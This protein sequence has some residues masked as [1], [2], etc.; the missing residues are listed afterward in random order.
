MSE[1]SEQR[2]VA[3]EPAEAHRGP[4]RTRRIIAAVVTVVIVAGLATYASLALVAPAPGATVTATS[5]VVAVPAAASFAVP[6]GG[7][8]AVSVTGAE[9]FPGTTGTDG[10]LATGGPT[11]PRPIASITKLIAALVILD[12]NPIGAGEDGPTLTFS[13]ADADLYDEY[14]VLGA[15]IQPMKAGA[16]MTLHDALEVMLVTSATNYAEAVSRWAFGSRS[17]FRAATAA[18][19]S[20]NGIANTTIVE[21]TGVDAGNT[22]TPTD[23]IA[24]GRLALANPVIAEIVAS[25]VL[26]VPGLSGVNTNTLVGE[27]GVTGLK[28]GTGDEAGACLLYSAVI[29]V[30]AGQPITVIG[31]VLGG[32]NRNTVAD[33]VVALLDSIKAGFH[34]VPVVA[35]DDELGSYTTP[36]GDEATVV[37]GEGASLFTWS[38]MPITSSVELAPVTAANDG[39]EVGTVTFTAG[40]QTVTVP[41]LLAGETTEPDGWWRLTHP[42]E[43]F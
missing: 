15:T 27:H 18:W 35:R 19:L 2:S 21:P 9:Q 30:G 20:A 33:A 8:S 38:D 16:R 12:A 5:P 43:L 25:P 24:I 41:L 32:G 31:A 34:S 13:E 37:A 23:L 10:I 3:P 26:D 29:D 4:R 28:T 6:T 22:S 1:L 40:E 14:Y 11:E 42:A 36:W 7:S 39:D 17:S